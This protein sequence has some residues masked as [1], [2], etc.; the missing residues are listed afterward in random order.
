MIEPWSF[1]V[2]VYPTKI[3]LVALISFLTLSYSSAGSPAYPLF[4]PHFFVLLTMPGFQ[5]NLL[6]VSWGDTGFNEKSLDQVLAWQLGHNLPLLPLGPSCPL[7]PILLGDL[8]R[9]QFGT[10]LFEF[11]FPGESPGLGSWCLLQTKIGGFLLQA[12]PLCPMMICHALGQHYPFHDDYFWLN[13]K[14]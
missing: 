2:R 12:R 11:K 14:G 6:P 1:Y 4:R 9:Y 10:L 5:Y 3:R 7:Q 13:W 8:V